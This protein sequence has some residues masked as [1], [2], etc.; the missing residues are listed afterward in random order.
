M[1]SLRALSVAIPN[2]HRAQV[3]S[4]FYVVAYSSLSLPAVLAGIVVTPLGTKLCRPSEEVLEILP[5]GKTAP[6]AKEDGERIED[7][8]NDQ[9]VPKAN[10]PITVSWPDM[11][12]VMSVPPFAADVLYNSLLRVNKQGIWIT[13]KLTSQRGSVACQ[14]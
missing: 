11:D 3:M 1:G 12:T 9:P 5:V 14:S 8:V 4:A 2:E 7:T 10:P 13:E 6:F